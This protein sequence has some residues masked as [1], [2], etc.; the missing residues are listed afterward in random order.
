MI[1]SNVPTRGGLPNGFRYGDHWKCEAIQIYIT[2]SRRWAVPDLTA[3]E[4][5]EFKSAWSK[6]NVK[7]V[8]AHVPFLVNLASPK[9][10]LRKKS[11][12]RLI[13]EIDRAN[14]FGVPYLVLHPG[15]NPNREEGINYIVAGLNTILS[16]D[17]HSGAKIL[18]E[19]VAGQG[20]SI[21][22]MFEELAF[23]IE[24]VQ[25]TDRLGVCFDTCH[26]FAAGYNFRGY[27]G[28]EQVLKQFDATI[29]LSR[30]GVFHIN[31]S[32]SNRGSRVDRHAHSIGEGFIGLQAFHAL[33]QDSRFFNT[34]MILEIPERDKKSKDSVQILKD[35]RLRK[36]PIIENT[37]KSSLQLTL[38]GI[39]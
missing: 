28:Y 27:D 29:G 4:I 7:Q 21:G 22:F 1:G 26:V 15:S 30:I 24:S 3:Q 33:L 31:D 18:L 11:I 39:F 19:T 34:P 5:A 20:N 13:I 14:K 16:I 12:D 10:D 37:S 35:L 17:C 8:V 36:E 25:R 9:S 32:E 23:I 6:S 2:L 38:E